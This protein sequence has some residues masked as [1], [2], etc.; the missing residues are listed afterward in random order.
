MT[1]MDHPGLPLRADGV[2]DDVRDSLADAFP[3][4]ES[5]QTLARLGIRVAFEV[6]PSVILATL[7][8]GPAAMPVLPS[9]LAGLDS[10]NITAAPDGSGAQYAVT[11]SM[12][13]GVV[14]L[15]V[16]VPAGWVTAAELATLINTASTAAEETA[17]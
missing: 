2:T 5:V 9:L 1:I 14:I 12:C 16:L 6:S 4:F 17:R 3:L 7:T 13:Q 11:G 15:R 10:A 8:V